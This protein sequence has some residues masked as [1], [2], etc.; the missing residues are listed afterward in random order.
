MSL[1]ITNPGKALALSYLTAKDTTVEKLF[2]K[3]YSN[4]TLPDVTSAATS[5]TQVTTANGYTSVELSGANW[6]IV[7]GQAA[8]PEITW[9]FTGAIGNI[10]GYYVVTESS[11]VA[12]FAERFANAPFI[13]ST[14]GDSLKLTV[15]LN[16]TN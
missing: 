7:D 12:V 14:T 9:N 10:Y 15:I 13:V 1:I 5:F 11:D 6:N 3:L 4:D 2:L 16:L 8:Y